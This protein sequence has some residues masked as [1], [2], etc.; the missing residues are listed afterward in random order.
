MVNSF[1]DEFSKFDNILGGS[2]V[3]AAMGVGGTQGVL[4]D[5]FIDGSRKGVREFGKVVDKFEGEFD[6]YFATI[7]MAGRKGSGVE[8]FAITIRFCSECCVF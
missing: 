5:K 8:R 3:S 4:L 7:G 1:K 6:R 2:K